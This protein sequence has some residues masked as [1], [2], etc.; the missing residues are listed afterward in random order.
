MGGKKEFMTSVKKKK[1][2]SKRFVMNQDE[3]LERVGGLKES[4][5][6]ISEM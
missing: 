1:N 2:P 5:F 4:S 3:K 6:I